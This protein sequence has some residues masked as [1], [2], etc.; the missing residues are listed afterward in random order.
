[1]IKFDLELET[2]LYSEFVEKI[3]TKDYTLED[4]RNH[5][6]I[7]AKAFCKMYKNKYKL[8]RGFVVDKKG[9]EH[10][11]WWCERITDNTIYDPTVEQFNFK[12]I[13]YR[14]VLGNNCMYCDGFIK[15]DDPSNLICD[16]KACRDKHNAKV[17]RNIGLHKFNK[18]FKIGHL[19]I[20]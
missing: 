2:K 16:K 18:D 19:H 9:V 12:I 14:K 5:C 11:H 10:P 3:N 7:Y 17:K 6:E 15:T 4:I 8:T 1:M 13:E 20:E